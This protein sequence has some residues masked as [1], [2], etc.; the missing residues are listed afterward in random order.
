MTRRDGVE[1]RQQGRCVVVHC[2]PP[3]DGL[4]LV[5]E[6]DEALHQR[7]PIVGAAV[8]KIDVAAGRRLVQPSRHLFQLPQQGHLGI[9]AGCVG[10]QGVRKAERVRDHGRAWLARGSA[11][12]RPAISA[13]ASR[14]VPASFSVSSSGATSFFML[15]SSSRPFMYV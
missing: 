14:R 2:Q 1:A 9:E 11:A 3:A 6:R 5:L 4:Q 12:P 15:P 8:E 13:H 10:S 7:R